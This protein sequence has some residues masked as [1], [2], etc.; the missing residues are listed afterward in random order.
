MNKI[1][2]INCLDFIKQLKNDNVKVDL[3]ITDPPYNISRKNNFKTI[4]RQ[5]IDFAWDYNFNQTA[6]IEECVDIIKDT[7]SILIF[8]SWKNMGELSNVLEKHNFHIKDLI[9]FKKTNPMPRNIHSR[10]VSDREFCLWATKSNKW[11]FNKPTNVKY[12]RPEFEEGNVVKRIHPTQKPLN[13]AKSLI[14]IHS[15]EGEL[16]FDPFSGS[17]TFSVAAYLLN[18]KYIAC[19]IDSSYY[20]SSLN[21]LNSFKKDKK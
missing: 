17:G 11:T 3:V 2:N 5:G 10:Y 18:R 1:Y 20:E 12:L 8:N 7:G 9:T 4:N 6:W 21:Y 13:L 19:E 16:I 14:S 15:N